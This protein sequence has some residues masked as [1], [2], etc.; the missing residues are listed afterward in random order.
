MS[1]FHYPYRV[2]G[3]D[4]PAAAFVLLKVAAHYSDDW[5]PEVPALVDTGAD[6]TVLPDRVVDALGL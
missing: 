4:R 5:H 6:L 3:P 1:V 2:P